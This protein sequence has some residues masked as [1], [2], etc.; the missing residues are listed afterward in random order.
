MSSQD[1]E[2]VIARL[3]TEIQRAVR[4]IESLRQANTELRKEIAELAKVARQREEDGGD[5]DA[6][7]AWSSERR[8]IRERVEGLVGGLE[9][10]LATAQ[11]A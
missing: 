5:P 6:P 3:E 2:L 10:L 9:K 8:E 11:E 4:E 7:A 1:P